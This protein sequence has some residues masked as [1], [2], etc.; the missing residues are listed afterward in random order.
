MAPT[1]CNVT[2]VH[3]VFP[4][5]LCLY[6]REPFTSPLTGEGVAGAGAKESEFQGAGMSLKK[7]KEMM[8]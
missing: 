8:L 6:R 7:S 2:K 5:P 1:E 3:E 4:L